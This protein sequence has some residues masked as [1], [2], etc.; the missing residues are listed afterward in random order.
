MV[1]IDLI[2]G[3]LGAGKTTFIKKYAEYL[4]RNGKSIGILENDYGAVNVDM[5]LLQDL[6][7]QLCDLEMVAGGCDAD[8]HKRRFKT[9]LIA[10]GML[11]YDRVLVEPSGIFDVDEFFD[12]LYESPLDRWYEI[13]NVI[14]I[15]DAGL[16]TKLSEASEYL[17]GSE[18][19]SAGCILYS[20][21]QEVSEAQRD[22]TKDYLQEVIEKMGC[23]QNHTGHK[24]LVLEKDWADFTDQDFENI[25]K[26]GYCS[27]SYTKRDPEEIGFETEYFMN[28]HLDEDAL[29]NK[30]KQLFSDSS[31][32]NVFRVK[33]FFQKGQS[34]DQTDSNW[35][36]YNA[37]G[38]T[39]KITPLTCGQDVMIII[40]EDLN[41]EKIRELY[42][43]C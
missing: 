42:E 20:R 5:M 11:G 17:L 8:C 43:G 22:E 40:G 12:V 28:L 36:E 26:S 13:G 9:K 2:T 34:A 15:V 38:N 29:R 16:D 31:F 14:A 6:E 27:A 35:M 39:E 30:T 19:A 1:K 3:F 23:G 7:G 32:G 41:S 21:T 24:K 37:T 33:G 18:A 4:M 10:L 25:M